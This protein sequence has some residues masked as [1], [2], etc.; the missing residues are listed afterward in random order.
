[1]VIKLLISWW[2][3]IS[4][5]LKGL[6]VG[7]LIG[8]LN[9]IMFILGILLSIRKTNHPFLS[10]IIFNDISNIPLDWGIWIVEKMGCNTSP[11]ILEASVI[12]IIIYGIFGLGFGFLYNKLKKKK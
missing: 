11:C 4:Y 12:S 5:V 9:S 3:K 2:G 6:I 10:Q 8:G 7:L 1:M